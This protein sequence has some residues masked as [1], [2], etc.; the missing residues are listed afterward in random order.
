MINAD[1]T[2]YTFEPVTG[3]Q[4]KLVFK[5]N[6]RIKTFYFYLNFD[7]AKYLEVRKGRIENARIY[8][9]PGNRPLVL[10]AKK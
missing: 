5:D 1:P 8:S 7:L 9:Y 2:N 4:Y 10:E 6:G 3:S